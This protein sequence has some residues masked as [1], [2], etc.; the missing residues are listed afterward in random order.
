MVWLISG[1]DNQLHM[2]REDKLSHGYTEFQL[3]KYFPE[4]INLETLVL[5]INVYYYDNGK[6]YERFV[7]SIPQSNRIIIVIFFLN[8]RRLTAVACECGLVKISMINVENLEIIHEWMLRYD[9]P[10]TSVQIFPQHS[11]GMFYSF[12]D[13]GDDSIF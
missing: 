9:K 6:R 12:S 10:V 3:D 5:W 8:Y 11:D 4:L 13:N 2:I 7:T 1:N